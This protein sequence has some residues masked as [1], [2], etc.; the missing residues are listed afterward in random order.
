VKKI[1]EKCATSLARKRGLEVIAW[2]F[3]SE[4]SLGY[5][6]GCF[7]KAEEEWSLSHV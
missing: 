7:L 4:W 2:L 1:L 3:V 6:W 5:T